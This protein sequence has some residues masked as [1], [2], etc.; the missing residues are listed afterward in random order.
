MT[1]ENTMTTEKAVQEVMTE[2]KVQHK[3]PTLRRYNNVE[4]VSEEKQ[5]DDSIRKEIECLQ[6]NIAYVENTILNDDDDSE[7]SSWRLMKKG[8]ETA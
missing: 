1:T 4:K 8:Y 5:T 7:E 2:K 3:R 6:K